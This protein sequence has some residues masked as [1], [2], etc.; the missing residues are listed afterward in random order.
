MAPCGAWPSFHFDPGLTPWAKVMPLLRSWIV[1]SHFN[2]TQRIVLTHAMKHCITQNRVH[3]D[4][5]GSLPHRPPAQ[6]REP[7][8]LNWLDVHF[9]DC[10]DGT[11][12]RSDLETALPGLAHECLARHG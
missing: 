11:D 12:L 9:F 10:A 4:F 6:Y 5:F 1:R 7:K 3:T 8:I 2:T